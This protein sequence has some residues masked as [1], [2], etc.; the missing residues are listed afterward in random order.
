MKIKNAKETM[1]DLHLLIRKVEKH[2]DPKHVGPWVQQMVDGFHKEIKDM[3]QA[4]ADLKS[5]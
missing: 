4:L 5:L 3:G 1:E 2:K